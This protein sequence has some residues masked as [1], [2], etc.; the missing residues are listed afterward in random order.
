MFGYENLCEKENIGLVSS[1]IPY[2]MKTQNFS[3]E[4]GLSSSAK[5]KSMLKCNNLN[6]KPKNKQQNFYCFVVHLFVTSQ[7]VMQ[8]TVA[9][10]NNF[11]YFF[12]NIK[13]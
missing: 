12:K 6:L 3:Q 13:M 11:A 2:K 7:A 4:N 1:E 9:V 8:P 10:R 5:L